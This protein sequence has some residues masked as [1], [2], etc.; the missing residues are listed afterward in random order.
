MVSSV[1][2]TA[3]S[4]LPPPVVK[5]SQLGSIL[6]PLRKTKNPNPAFYAGL[7]AKGSIL[8]LFEQRRNAAKLSPDGLLSLGCEGR[9]ED[10]VADHFRN[11]DEG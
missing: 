4:T 1:V 3:R 8:S 10:V 5:R 6:S 11:G 2:C 9:E 7:A